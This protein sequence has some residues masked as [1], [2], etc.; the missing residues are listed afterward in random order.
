LPALCWIV[1][2]SPG[3]AGPLG[4][5]ANYR[6]ELLGCGPDSLRVTLGFMS[7]P[8]EGGGRFAE[9][10]TRNTK[11]Q[12]LHF[13]RVCC[14]CGVVLQNQTLSAGTGAFFGAS[15]SRAIGSQ[16][17]GHRLPALRWIASYSSGPSGPLVATSRL[18]TGENFLAAATVILR[19]TAR[20]LPLSREWGKFAN[21]TTKQRKEAIAYAPRLKHACTHL[22]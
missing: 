22:T 19:V 5:P 9:K 4:Q 10:Q 14:V 6:G 7:A 20:C 15:V 13:L 11:T 21:K 17:V 12:R 18:T 3:P 2:Y 16:A 1:S 8:F